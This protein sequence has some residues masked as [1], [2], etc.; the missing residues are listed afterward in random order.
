M[1]ELFPHKA[2]YVSVLDCFRY[3][4]KQNAIYNNTGSELNN[5][6]ICSTILNL[7]NF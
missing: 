6:L 4:H 5:M 2:E 3:E 7:N 1:S